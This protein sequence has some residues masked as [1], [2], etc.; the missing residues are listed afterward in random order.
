MS[1]AG[2]M[3]LAVER[4]LRVGCEAL[5]VFTSSPN[6]WAPRPIDRAE[7]DAFRRAVSDAGLAAVASHGSYLVN[8]GS[9]DAALR[10]RSIETTALELDR[11]AAFGIPYL[12]IHPGAHMGSGA[13]GAIRRIG[14]SVRRL[15]ERRAASA[16][17]SI[18]VRFLYEGTAGHGSCL[19]ATFEELAE[20]LAATGVPER[21]GV[22]LDTCHLFA[23]GYDVSSAEGLGRTIAEFDRTVGLGTLHFLHLNDSR[24]ECGSRVDRHEH[25]GRGKIGRAGFGRIVN[26]P[27][28]RGLPGVLE[29]R[30]SEDLHEDRRNLDVLR[31][32]RSAARRDA[33]PTAPKPAAKRSRKGSGATA[34]V[35]AARTKAATK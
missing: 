1:I 20:L 14:V 7:A 17:G 19:G 33:E 3:P 32:L 26:H 16:G 10:E 8:L 29:T 22:C 25:I 15:L 23:A 12:V 13:S 2:G 34:P 11:C 28:L 5:Q 31:A 18:A 6:R 30:K 27:A 35:R 24:R 21:T 4:A 9:S